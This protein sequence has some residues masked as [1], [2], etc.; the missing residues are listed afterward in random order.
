[1]HG[2]APSSRFAGIAPNP[3]KG[4]AMTRVLD[5]D[6]TLTGTAEVD[7]CANERSENEG[8]REPAA[9][10]ARNQVK[11]ASTLNPQRSEVSD[12]ER[13]VL[14]HERIL[15]A[16]IAHLSKEDPE[17]LLS[18]KNAFCDPI[19]VSHNEHDY[20]DTEA[21][22]EQFLRE[23]TRLGESLAGKALAP[24]DNRPTPRAPTL[25]IV[26][27]SPTTTVEFRVRQRTG[28]W[29]VTRDSKFFGD[30]RTE[31]LAL[32]HAKAA[33]RSIQDE[34]GLATL[35]GYAPEGAML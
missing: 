2:M 7:R 12:I 31:D 5:L 4:I 35:C 10:P 22:A 21:Y 19:R 26:A 25:P 15:Q 18:L 1:M 24:Q 20:T 23:V 8:M 9:R 33:I 14:A 32:K 3:G 13:R 27:S 28:I 34:G 6:P 11:R 30:Y 17:A 16:L 29:E